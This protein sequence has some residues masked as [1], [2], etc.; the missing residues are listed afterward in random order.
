MSATPEIDNLKNIALG[1]AYRVA[2]N[3]GLRA[4]WVEANGAAD[5]LDEFIEAVEVF[6]SRPG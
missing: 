6:S 4:A 2:T 1:I 5:R 3:D